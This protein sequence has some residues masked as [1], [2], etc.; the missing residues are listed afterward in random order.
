MVATYTMGLSLFWI[1]QVDHQMVHVMMSLLTHMM[2]VLLMNMTEFL[3][4]AVLELTHEM[5]YSQ[6]DSK[7]RWRHILR[8]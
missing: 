4:E 7:G 2:V 8:W 6:E 5:V 1:H 3:P